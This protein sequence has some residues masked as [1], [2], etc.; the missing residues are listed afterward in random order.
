MRSIFE[1]SC[2]VTDVV[3][4]LTRVLQACRLATRTDPKMNKEGVRACGKQHL[5]IYLSAYI[6]TCTNEHKS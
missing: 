5:S 4:A 6:E 3:E 2:E 1:S